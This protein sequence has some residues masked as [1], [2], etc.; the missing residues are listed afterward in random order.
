MRRLVVYGIDSWTQG[1]V[2]EG[3]ARIEEGVTGSASDL[4]CW[5]GPCFLGGEVNFC[6][7]C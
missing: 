4:D 7:Q 3:E 1:T 5:V 6:K 2:R